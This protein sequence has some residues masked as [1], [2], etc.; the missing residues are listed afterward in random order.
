MAEK[1]TSEE[2]TVIIVGAGFAGV[3][4]FTQLSTSLDTDTKLIL[5]SP[6]PYLIHLPAAHRLVITPDEPNLADNV[7]IPL[8][9]RLNQGNRKTVQAKVV[10]ITDKGAT[11][12]VTLDNG[13]TIKYTVLILAP[14]SKWE[15]PFDFPDTKEGTLEKLRELHAR[16]EKSNDIVLVGGG[17]VSIELSGEIKDEW[18]TKNLTLVHSRD[19]LLNDAYPE[20]WRSN[21]AE[22]LKKRGINLVLGERVDDVEPKDGKISTRSGKVIP[23]DL[24]IGTRG[25]RPNTDFI[26]SS[27]G[28][29][30]VIDSGHVKVKPTLQL[31]SHPHIFAIGDI[32]D[33]D[34]QKSARKGVN[35]ARSVVCPN[36]VAFLKDPTTN[37]LTT[38]SSMFEKLTL[39]NGR[40]GGTMYI[41]KLWG[42]TFGDWVTSRKASKNLYMPGIRG[43]LRL[44]P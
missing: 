1:S 22:G 39:T 29:N 7:L 2:R 42:L 34:E 9:S 33:W 4:A 32:I 20:H 21:V 31:P 3:A 12:F 25:P 38:Y 5:I 8:P 18:P 17:A 28:A 6:R 44:N 15:S 24:V 43:Q 37:N 23:A 11:R 19:L 27:L 14:G 16:F 10:S 30:V 26:S 36:V 13:E 40:N 41:G 35:Q